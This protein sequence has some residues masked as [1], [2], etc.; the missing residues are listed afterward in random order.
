MLGL[1]VG[2][3]LEK[4]KRARGG[5]RRAVVGPVGGDIMVR[6]G[7]GGGQVGRCGEDGRLGLGDDGHR[8]RLAYHEGD[9]SR[10]PRDHA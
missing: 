9:E 4:L 7:V 5:G 6:D 3:E 10:R 2:C 8:A 1:S